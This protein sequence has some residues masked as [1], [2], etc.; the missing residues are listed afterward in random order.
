MLTVFQ[1]CFFVGVGL[2]VLSIIFSSFFEAMGIDG[3]DLDVDIFGVDIFIPV[4][5]ILFILFLTV[6]GGV[7]W[8]LIAEEYSLSI[9][10]ISII[11]LFTGLLISIMVSLLIIKPLKKAQNTS[12]P[13]AEELVGVRASVTETIFE[14]GFGEITYTI[15]GNSYNSPAKSTNGEEITKGKDVAICW[16][17]D[18]VFYVTAIE[19]SNLNS[20][21]LE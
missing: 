7:G 3:L 4:S 8:I 18:H 21:T 5:P 2:I 17:E 14:K 1:V 16:I 20:S 13:N 11:A 15:N 10:L 6:F 9:L 12:A 19:E